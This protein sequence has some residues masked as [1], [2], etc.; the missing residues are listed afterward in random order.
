MVSKIELKG[1]GTAK[2]L[3]VLLSVFANIFTLQSLMLITNLAL[4]N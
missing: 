3:F 2:E 4:K 1:I